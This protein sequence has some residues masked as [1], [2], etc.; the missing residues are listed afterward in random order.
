LRGRTEDQ[1]RVGG[2]ACP[3]AKM[4]ESAFVMIHTSI[5]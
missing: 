2:L 3:N 5:A 4:T 1:L